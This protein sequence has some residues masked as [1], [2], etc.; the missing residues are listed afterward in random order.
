MCGIIGIFGEAIELADVNAM[1]Q[2]AARRG[3]EGTNLK[4]IYNGWLGQTL[5]GFV[6]LGQNPQPLAEDEAVLVNNGEIYNWRELSNRYSLNAENDTQTLLRGLKS[7]G[8]KFLSLIDG[9]FAF[10]YQSTTK[11]Q[12]KTLI[13]RD[14]YGISPLVFGQNEKGQTVMGSTAETIQAAG[15]KN[16]K[17]L[18]AGS[19]AWLAD[20]NVTLSSWFDLNSVY[21]EIQLEKDPQQLLELAR[22]N[23]I[24]RIPEQRAVLY[25]TL[26]GMDSG[27][28]TATVARATSGEFGGA[29]T[30]VP[31]DK[32]K[33][34]DLRGGDWHSATA[35]VELLKS[36]GIFINHQILQLTPDYVDSALDRILRVLG[37]DYYNVSCAL[38]E[39]LVASAVK[40]RMGKAIMTAGGP[41]EAGRS[42]KP[43]TL[44]HR[45]NAEEAWCALGDQ[46]SSSEGVRAGLV[47]GE[48]G[49][50]NR[51]PLAQLIEYFMD[52][53][54]WQKQHIMDWGDGIDPY[55]IKMQ[56]KIAWRTALQDQLPASVL[57]T[58]KDTIHGATGSKQTLFEVAKSDRLFQQEREDFIDF[59]I[60]CGWG[61][62]K[63]VIHG[64]IKNLDPSDKTTEGQLYTLYRWQH[65]EPEQFA[66]GENERYGWS[67]L[68][69][70]D[71]PFKSANPLCYDWKIVKP[72][73]RY[74][75]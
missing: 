54:P 3:P 19:I 17:S 27:F 18:P 5:L 25:T 10:I 13:G 61:E 60:Q 74:F 53:A 67:D 51:V 15:V 45:D 59:A 22:N 55:T 68:Y 44:L 72:R 34:N 42:Y 43:W 23:V 58:P 6:A 38:A 65:V 11:G 28:V 20:G 33:P 64:D 9:Q 7:M 73:M 48:H 62:L 50:E 69:S 4:E 12:V 21:T 32:E 41:D 30:V 14:R 49:L 52:M 26:G 63:Q 31:W 46:F 70:N 75:M 37:P 35:V 56:D 29:V 47:F 8:E 36:E 57:N 71:L 1:L 39:D 2:V 66:R 40:T 24:N 16:V